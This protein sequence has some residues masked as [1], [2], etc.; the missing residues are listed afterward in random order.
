MP[1]KAHLARNLAILA[2]VVALVSAGTYAVVTY[3][4][5]THSGVTALATFYPVY[6]H[7]RN[8]AAG[9]RVNVAL[10]VPMTLDV[11]EFDPTPSSVQAVAEADLLIYSGAGLEPW[12][13]RIVSAAGNAHLTLV[14]SSKDVSLLQVPAQFQKENRTTDPH[15]WLDPILAKQQVSNILAGLIKADPADAATFTANAAIYSDKLDVL[16]RAA[17]NLTTS[18]DLKTRHFVTF[19]EAFAYFAARYNLDQIPI[20]GPFEEEPTPSEIQSVINATKQYHLCYIGYESLSNPEIARSIASQLNA[21]TTL[22]RLDPIEGLSLEDQ[23]LG[24]TY[25]TKMGDILSK[26]DLMLNHVGCN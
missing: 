14:D 5:A 19:H 12:I 9:T 24:L 21:T 2:V 11:H 1:W 26:L 3:R 10:L 4:P 15:I 13:A 20:A 8:I 17:L 22:I 25:L 6:E 18:P 23:A 16:N 7:T